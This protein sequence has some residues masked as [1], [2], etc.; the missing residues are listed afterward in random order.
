VLDIPF[1]E[2][3]LFDLPRHAEKRREVTALPQFQDAQLRRAE[4]RIEGAVAVT[5]RQVVRSPLRS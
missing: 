3:V 4:T 2:Q 5:V 1:I